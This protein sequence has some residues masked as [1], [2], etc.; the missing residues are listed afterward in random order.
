MMPE[1]I[2]KSVIRHEGKTHFPENRFTATEAVGN[3][4]VEHKRAV[5]A[6][7]ADPNQPLEEKGVTELRSL[8]KAAGV[9]NYWDKRKE[10]L[11][12]D[13]KAVGNDESDSG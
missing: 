5:P 11:V 1:Y 8:A 13:L 2:A 4:L 12:A 9:K 10:E 3:A 7:V 6:E